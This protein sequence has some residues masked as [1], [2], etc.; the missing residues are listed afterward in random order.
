M[1]PLIKRYSGDAAS[2]ACL[3][4]HLNSRYLLRW[5]NLGLIL[6]LA[7]DVVVIIVR[8]FEPRGKVGYKCGI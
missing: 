4:G 2:P 6:V 5:W 1:K 7:A 3:L 8:Y